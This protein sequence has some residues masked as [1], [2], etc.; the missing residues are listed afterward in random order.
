MRRLLLPVLLL[1]LSIGT[2][3]AAHLSYAIHGSVLGLDA[4]VA[5]IEADLQLE[6]DAYDVRLSYRTAGV[7]SLIVT[8]SN[9]SEARGRFDHGAASPTSFTSAGVFRGEQRR[10]EIAYD[11]GVPDVR[12]LVPPSE[13]KRDPVPPAEQRGTIDPMSAMAQLVSTVAR[14]G[15][16]DGTLTTFDG[17][18]VVA[19]TARTAGVQDLS[20]TD[21]STF[22]GPALRCDVVSQQIAGFKHD[23]DEPR[24][25]RPQSSSAWFARITPAGP[26]LLVRATFPTVFLGLVTMYLTSAGE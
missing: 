5:S 8:A 22:A 4:E 14:T 2:A 6:P 15:R 24:M 3:E 18:R 9:A 26:P 16:C 19:F 20:R 11:Q 10:V 23:D 12:A 21:R 7:T 25:H 17:R 1:S 13:P